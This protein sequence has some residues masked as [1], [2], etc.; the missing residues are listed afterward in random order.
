MLSSQSRGGSFTCLGGARGTRTPSPPWG[1]PSRWAGCGDKVQGQ[2]LLPALDL[3]CSLRGRNLF[4]IC[5]LKKEVSEKCQGGRRNVWVK[6]NHHGM[7]VTAVATA[8]AGGEAPDLLLLVVVVV[9]FVFVF[10]PCKHHG[11]EANAAQGLRKQ[12]P[13]L[14]WARWVQGQAQEGTGVLGSRDCR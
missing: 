10:P 9:V 6:N 2:P 7:G 11:L 14:A 13:A 12:G 1:S 4:P 8:R 3:G 5:N